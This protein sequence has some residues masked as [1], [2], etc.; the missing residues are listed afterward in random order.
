MFV[1]YCKQ[2]QIRLRVVLMGCKVSGIVVKFF[3]IDVAILPTL[4]MDHRTMAS[5]TPFTQSSILNI[6][7]LTLTG[8]SHAVSLPA[9]KGR[10]NHSINQSINSI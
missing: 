3:C 7:I 2:N 5:Q 9:G 10:V 8:A 1:V 4:G 6:Q